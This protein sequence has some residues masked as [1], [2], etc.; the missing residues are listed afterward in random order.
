MKMLWIRRLA[1]AIG[2]LVVL[3]AAAA[4]LLIA[5]FDANRYKSIAIDW[6]KSERQR[7]LAID[8]PIKLSVFPRLTVEVSKVRLS[9]RGRA[10]EFLAADEASLAVQV[11][12]LLRKRLVVDRVNARGVRVTYA[13]DARGLRNIDDFASGTGAGSA[14]SGA[15]LQFDV[16]AVRLDDL[17]LHLR[18]E[19]GHVAG[20]VAV[21]SF[22]AGHLAD[23]TESPV[24]LRATVRLTQPRAVKLALDGSMSVALD[25]E[26]SAVALTDLKIDAQGDAASLTGLSLGLE[27]ALAWDGKALR[28]A[29][30]HAAL[31]GGTLG[32]ISFAP[33]TLDVKRALVSPASQRLELDALKLALV[34]RQGDSAFELSLEWPRLVVDA[35]SLEGSALSGRFQFTGATALAGSYRSEAPSGNFDALRLPG[36]AAKLEG[37]TGQR[38]FEGIATA[39]VVLGGAR[40]T[41]AF[42]RLD[43]RGTLADPNL[44][45]LQLTLGGNASTDVETAQWALAG[46]LDASRFESTGRASFAGA[47]PKVEAEAR[48]DSLD[49]NRLLALDKPATAPAAPAA[50]ADAPVQLAGL[51]SVAGQFTFSSGA[52]AFRQYRASDVKVRAAL[53]EGAL[54][55]TRLT[56]RAW[57]GNVEASGSA[58]ARGHHIAVKLA[59]SGVDVDALLKNV[60]GKDLLAGTGRVVADVSSNGTSIG[61]LRSNL[62]GTVALQVRNGA[63][64]GVNLARAMRQLKAALSMKQDSVIRASATER[65]DFSEFTAS[66]RIAAG[67]AQSDDLDVKAPFLRIGGAG[68]FDIGRGRVD[69]TARVSVIGSP[70]GQ[71]GAELAALRGLTVPVVLSGPFD[72]IDWKIQWSEV[73]AAAVEIKLREMIAERLGATRAPGAAASAS[74]TSKGRLLEQLKGLLK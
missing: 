54:R 19:A 41:V 8:G 38:K 11:L 66:A 50:P 29:P 10:D 1:I 63:I 20:E 45:P 27:G 74:G 17:R 69:Y 25:L 34:G 65:T 73:A 26:R 24:S 12:P 7:T 5:N 4:A 70:S 59:A 46:S 61:A 48:F 60:A 3:L 72:A 71:D 62:A 32:A 21:Q 44:Q 35:R 6:M 33:S 64:K 16:R 9:E 53:D 18:D 56:G 51:N 68:R 52:L 31:K 22:S 37:S 13:R 40:G 14:P 49:L 23:R 39:D 36:I 30:L 67:I 55:V 47:V 58:E 57:G 28:A 2:A 43:V 15:A 42:E